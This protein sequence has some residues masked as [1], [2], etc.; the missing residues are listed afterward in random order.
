[1]S[2]DKTKDELR[3]QVVR[4]TNKRKSTARWCKG[5]EGREHV[6]ELVVNHNYN[7]GNR[8]TC[9]WQEVMR[10]HNHERQHWRWYYFCRHSYKC[11]NCGKYTEDRLKNV[12]ECPEYTPRP[13]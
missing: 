8:W 4:Q 2:W 5:K 7:R 3:D 11:V 1:M 12:E 13:V 6:P 10:Y 9:R